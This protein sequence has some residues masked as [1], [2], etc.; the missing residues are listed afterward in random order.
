M[1]TAD[2]RVVLGNFVNNTS[3]VISVVGPVAFSNDDA[4]MYQAASLGNT[5]G[6]SRLEIFDV[7][8]FSQTGSIDLGHLSNQMAPTVKDLIVDG[9][10]ACIFVATGA[11]VIQVSCESMRPAGEFS[12]PRL[13]CRLEAF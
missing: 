5:D 13:S 9:S 3:S 2:V 1:S 11:T 7:A 8:S 4:V 12:R 6:M 10:D